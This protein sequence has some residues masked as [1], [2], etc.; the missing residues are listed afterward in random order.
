MKQLEGIREKET[1]ALSETRMKWTGYEITIGEVEE[2][3]NKLKEKKAAG[4]A[5]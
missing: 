1:P 3:I 2:A 4:K 5:E